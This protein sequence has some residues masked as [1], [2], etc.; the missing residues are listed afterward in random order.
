MFD[1]ITTICLSF[2]TAAKQDVWH[3]HH[4]PPCWFWQD[5]Y[6]D[7]GFDRMATKMLVSTGWLPRCLMSSSSREHGKQS[8]QLS[9]ATCGQSL[10]NKVWTSQSTLTVTPASLD[11]NVFVSCQRYLMYRANNTIMPH[12]TCMTPT[13]PVSFRQSFLRLH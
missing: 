5:G 6:Q 12:N 1:T 4:H 8:N 11:S 2:N 3:W 7:V 13:L 10:L 9:E